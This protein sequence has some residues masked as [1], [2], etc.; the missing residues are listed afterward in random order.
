[1]A[2][3][4]TVGDSV[5]EAG[6]D[7][8]SVTGVELRPNGGL[9]VQIH[10]DPHFRD[11]LRQRSTFVVTHP[12]DRAR[13]VLSLQILDEDSPPLPPGGLLEG[14]DSETEL[15]IRTEIVKAEKALHAASHQIEILQQT[16]ESVRNSKERKELEN[17]LSG[18]FDT[19]RRVQEEAERIIAE[20]LSKMK[21]WYEKPTS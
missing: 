11:R 5:V 1:M 17:S 6:T 4:L 16:I 14:A 19:L 12:S 15:T 2:H 7:I 9:D 3:G 21:K 8:G 20:E 18:L 13:P 10:I